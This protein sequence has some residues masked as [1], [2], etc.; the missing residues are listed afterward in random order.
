MASTIKD[1]YLEN[2]VLGASPIELLRMLYTAAIQAVQSA[3]TH[4][5]S[6]DIAARSKAISQAQAI[7]NE[8]DCSLDRDG[9]GELAARLS[10]LYEYMQTRLTQANLDQSE[11]PLTEVERLLNTL[12]EGWQGAENLAMAS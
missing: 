2:R 5:G 6:G 10:Q 3:R 7:L 12:Q 4:L 1:T 9:G 11:V 8:L